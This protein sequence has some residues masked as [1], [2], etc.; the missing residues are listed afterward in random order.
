MMAGETTCRVCLCGDA[1]LSLYQQETDMKIYLK[2]MACSAVQICEED[3]FPG[4]ICSVCYTMLNTAFEFKK[5]CELSDLKLRSYIPKTPLKVEEDDYNFDYTEDDFLS[6]GYGCNEDKSFQMEVDV[7]LFDTKEEMTEK[8]QKKKVGKRKRK[9]KIAE[10]QTSLREAIKKKKIRVPT[11]KKQIVTNSIA[12][13]LLEGKCIWNGRDWRFEMQSKEDNNKKENYLEPII[14]K[15]KE[16]IAQSDEKKTRRKKI[17]NKVKSKTM[18]LCDT[19]GKQFK[20]KYHLKYHIVLKHQETTGNI[21][22][23]DPNCKKMFKLDHY[24]ARH[25]KRCHSAKR[26]FVCN[27]CGK[28]YAFISS[29]KQ[30]MKSHSENLVWKYCNFCS[31]KYRTQK[32]VDIH[33]RSVHTGERPSVCTVCD[34]AF[35]HDDYLKEH[36]RLHTGETPYKCPICKRGYAQRGNMKSHMKQHRLSELDDATKATM[37]PNYLKLLRTC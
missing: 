34:A 32:S 28:Q 37:K 24:M 31:Q 11:Y 21:K 7:K 5:R 15:E 16:D 12:T 25:V 8:L 20:S 10:D 1:H 18:N 23:L 13:S 30:H 9:W 36:M 17:N 27:E 26:E 35:F 6:V 14:K 2:V 19:C 3:G 22:C 4:N 33:I 29:L